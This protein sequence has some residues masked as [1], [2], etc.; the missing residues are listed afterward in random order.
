MLAEKISETQNFFPPLAQNDCEQSSSSH[1][2]VRRAG[3]AARRKFGT[4]PPP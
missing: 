1:P 3:F 2:K 4:H